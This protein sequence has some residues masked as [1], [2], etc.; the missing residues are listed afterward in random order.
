MLY[1]VVVEKLVGVVIVLEVRVE[2]DVVV[3]VVVV[4]VK[5]QIV[6]FQDSQSGNRLNVESLP[7]AYFAKFSCPNC[8]WLACCLKFGLLYLMYIIE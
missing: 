2:F 7:F 5:S 4:V 1:V 8:P 3:V 6:M